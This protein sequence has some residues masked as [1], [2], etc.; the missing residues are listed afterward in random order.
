[1]AQIQR[2]EEE[3]MKLPKMIIKSSGTS[4]SFD[5]KKLELAVNQSL[6]ENNYELR[7]IL[8]DTVL[9]RIKDKNTTSTHYINDI[10]ETYL[11]KNQHYE[12]LQKYIQNRFEKNKIHSDKVNLL[13][14]RLVTD[15]DFDKGELNDFS[16]NQIQ[17]AANRYPVSYTH[18]R[19]HET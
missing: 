15:P 14:T 7:Q 18:L 17:I 9:E 10:I 12:V 8:I 5:I 16:V 13:G 19:A 6:G 4:E 1:M 11:L 3:V 2:S